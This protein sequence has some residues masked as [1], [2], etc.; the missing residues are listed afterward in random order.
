MKKKES[1]SSILSKEAE[2]NLHEIKSLARLIAGHVAIQE[3]EKLVST[4]ERKAIWFL[5]SGKLTREHIVSQSG[6]SLRTVTSFIDMAKT[7][8]LLEEE[9]EKGGHPRRVIDYAPSEWKEFVKMKKK[10]SEPKPS[11]PTT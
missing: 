1:V 6:I 9:M 2:E 8:G 4:N 5:C 11:T 3:I 7:L 10:P